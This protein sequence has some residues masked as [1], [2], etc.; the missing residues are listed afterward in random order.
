ML[1]RHVRLMRTVFSILAVL[2]LLPAGLS[3]QV[4]GD[5]AIALPIRGD[6]T[7]SFETDEGT[8]MSLD[9]SPDGQSVLFDLVGDL[10]VV[11]IGGGEA[12]RITSGI[13]WDCM[14]RFSPDGRQIA[15]ISDRSGSDNLWVM[16]IDGTGLRQVT[17]ET[18]FALSSPEWAPD[19]EYIVARKFGAYPGPVD[20]L[21]SVPL[22]IF[23][24]AGGSGLELV[25]A[26]AG[27]GGTTTN[28]GAAFSPDGRYV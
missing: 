20:Y 28:T 15:F 21:R 10:Y 14:P 18:D 22:W 17:K 23:H 7:I 24:K 2:T 6:R 27:G 1:D 13:A 4:S 26:G 9:V 11:P 3:A 25:P 5:T 19:G 16:N 12:R 8:W